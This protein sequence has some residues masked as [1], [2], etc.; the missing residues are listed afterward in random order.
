MEEEARQILRVALQEPVAQTLDLGTRIRARFA[1]FGDV[2]LPIETRQSLREP[3]EPDGHQQ[4][5]PSAS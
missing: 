5:A 1:A 3:P 4:A 2:Q